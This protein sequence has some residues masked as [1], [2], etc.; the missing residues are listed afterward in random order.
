MLPSGRNEDVARRIVRHSRRYRSHVGRHTKQQI[1]GI[2]VELLAEESPPGPRP[3][4][5][6]F[7]LQISCDEHRDTLVEAT[8]ILIGERKIIWIRTDA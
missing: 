6:G 1:T 2:L 8:S 3:H 5:N 4:K 7:A